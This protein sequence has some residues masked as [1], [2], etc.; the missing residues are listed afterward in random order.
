MIYIIKIKM[1]SHWVLFGL[2]FILDAAKNID[3]CR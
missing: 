2:N 3:P 1:K